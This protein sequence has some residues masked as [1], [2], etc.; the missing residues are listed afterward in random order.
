MGDDFKGLGFWKAKDFK[1]KEE[2][3][4]KNGNLYY[5]HKI[6]DKLYAKLHKNVSENE[7]A[8]NLNLFLPDGYVIMKKPTE[9]VLNID[10]I[11]KVVL[12]DQEVVEEIDPDDIPF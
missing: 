4:D 12:E 1:T 2:K 9:N 8:P 5:E 11:D 7:K 10:D 6:A 3:R